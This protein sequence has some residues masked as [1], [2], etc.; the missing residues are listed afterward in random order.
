MIETRGEVKLVSLQNGRVIESFL[1]KGFDDV[2]KRENYELNNVPSEVQKIALGIAG[3]GGRCFLEGGCVRDGVV[4]NIYKN[5]NVETK[6]FD[7]EVYG[8]K[9]E[10]VMIHLRNTY[11]SENVQVTGADFGVIRIRIPGSNLQLEMGVPRTERK[12]GGGHKDFE[13][14]SVPWIKMIDAALRRDLS[15]NSLLYDPLSKTLY[16][17]YGGIQDIED[18]MI[19]ANSIS[20]FVED[21]LRVLRVMQFAARFGFKI[22]VALK[23]ACGRLVSEGKMQPIPEFIE[24]AKRGKFVL[25][26][27]EFKD[28]ERGFL[29]AEKSGRVKKNVLVIPPGVSQERLTQETVKMLLKGTE[30]WRGMEFMREIGYIE[31]YWPEMEALVGLEQGKMHPEGDVWTHTLEAMNAGRKILDRE[32]AAGRI[33][34]DERELFE[35]A[36]MFA[37]MLHDV[38]KVNPPNEKGYDMHDQAAG[39]IIDGFF[40][41]MSHEDVRDKTRT[42]V[43]AL[44]KEHMNFLM[45]WKKY[46]ELQEYL[47]KNG[48]VKDD[49]YK[50]E[51]NEVE[52]LAKRMDVRLGGSKNPFRATLYMMAI[53]S[54]ADC[55]ARNPNTKEFKPI[56]DK[57]SKDSFGLVDWAYLET[58]KLEE[59]ERSGIKMPRGHILEALKLEK[60]KGQGLIAGVIFKSLD[61]DVIDG[62]T[63]IND[64]ED[65]T[66]LALR[67]KE[68]FSSYV[69]G[70][71]QLEGRDEIEIW[72]EIVKLDD[73]RVLLNN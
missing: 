15:M 31:K 46:R 21:P 49:H 65:L 30:P 14:K 68:A 29:I 58:K 34:K 2:P 8:V 61:Q 1:D 66:R 23:E 35:M 59:A 38:G 26:E 9:Y 71:A 4:K 33:S 20:T 16:D 57:D 73:P 42:Q 54:E 67:Y 45:M 37:I 55:M 52:K 70:R 36:V 11:G 19:K 47:K 3:I 24:R 51:E 10:D 64:L 25:G 63:A 32:E 72:S 69:K 22:D 13:T 5:L 48:G 50:K 17:P 40:A 7:M 56:E 12:T 41:K 6:D 39:P 44:A 60:S 43:K 53:M 27:E 62:M 18:G 28:D